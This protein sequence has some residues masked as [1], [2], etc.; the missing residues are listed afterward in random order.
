MLSA[1]KELEPG[2]RAMLVYAD[3]LFRLDIAISG[4]TLRTVVRNLSAAAIEMRRGA[5]G[6]GLGHVAFGEA[7]EYEPGSSGLGFVLL[8]G[9]ERVTVEVQIATLR[10]PQRGTVRVSAQAIVRQTT[11]S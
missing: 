8:D 6:Q 1:A 5:G 3:G 11:S 7:A 4:D 9:D 2:A 10:M